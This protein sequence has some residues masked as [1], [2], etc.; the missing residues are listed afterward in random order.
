MAAPAPN[1]FS[2]TREA[3][4]SELSEDYVEAILDLIDSHGEARL[5]D[6]AERMGVSHPSVFK[7]LRRMEADGLVN[8]RPYR[9]ILLTAQGRKLAEDCRARHQ[10][11]VSFLLALGLDRETAELDAEGIEHHVSPKTLGL[12]AEFTRRPGG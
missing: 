1:P 12:M 6:L 3:H 2:R 7:T 5:T 9:S 11:V 4:R 10:T 8:L